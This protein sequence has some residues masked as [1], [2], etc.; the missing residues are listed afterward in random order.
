MEKVNKNK[1]QNLE[2]VYH[3]QFYIQIG[4]SLQNTWTY[5]FR[6]PTHSLV[7]MHFFLALF[8]SFVCFIVSLYST[9]LL[10]LPCS[11]LAFECFSSGILCDII[12]SHNIHFF[13]LPLCDQEHSF[14]SG[15]KCW[16]SSLLG[17][18]IHFLLC[19][20]FF[21]WYSLRFYLCVYM[22]GYWPMQQTFYIN[23]T[24]HWNQFH[25]NL[26]EKSQM[27]VF[28]AYF[29]IRVTIVSWASRSSIYHMCFFS[30]LWL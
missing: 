20:V 8:S 30:L 29:R 9:L 24:F 4:S 11:A 21:D 17:S 26:L 13:S 6:H 10:G 28:C 27:G 18:S 7:D 5:I 19:I 22:C 1:H 15:T 3:R 2:N 23:V 16:I 12:S 14:F 25:I